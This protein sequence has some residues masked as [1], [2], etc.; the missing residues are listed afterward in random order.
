MIKFIRTNSNNHDLAPLIQQLD[1]YLRI[2]DGEDHAFFAQHNKLDHIK[3]V[4]IAYDSDKAIGC[5]AIKQQDEQTTEIKR[6]FV[7]PEYRGKGVAAHIMVKLEA[8]ARELGFSNA[9][10][11]TGTNN[12][13]A[14][15][16]YFKMGY[17]QIENYGQYV[18]VDASFCM[19]KSI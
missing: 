9:I 3:H 12:P 14:I 5:G 7:L 16:L 6:M 19:S 18:G 11:E 17:V 13:D 4:I 15:G 1:H 2:L 8:W 10:L